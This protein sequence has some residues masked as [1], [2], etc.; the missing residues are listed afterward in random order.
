MF[1]F[2]FPVVFS[3]LQ[4]E[5][6]VL[7]EL[8]GYCHTSNLCFVRKYTTYGACPGLF[9]N[10]GNAMRGTQTLWLIQMY[11]SLF[12]HSFIHPCQPRWV[13]KIHFSPTG[14][15]SSSSDT[16][17][18]ARFNTDTCSPLSSHLRADMSLISQD[19]QSSNNY[20]L[21][22]TLTPCSWQWPHEMIC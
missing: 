16:L 3:V 13:C 21:N 18:Q 1:L 7:P 22:H 2:S 5:V 12:I 20:I 11:P 15:F 8:S 19:L 10:E 9:K 17:S 6:E 14:I 4:A